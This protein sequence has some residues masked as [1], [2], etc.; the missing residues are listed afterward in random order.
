DLST[1]RA[2]IRDA[3][4]SAR[5]ADVALSGLLGAD[6]DSI[7][8]RGRILGASDA[9]LPQ[10]IEIGSGRFAA[11]SRGE[12]R[13]SISMDLPLGF[14]APPHPLLTGDIDATLDALLTPD[15]A[16]EIDALTLAGQQVSASARGRVSADNLDTTLS[17]QLDS[18]EQQGL[19]LAP[20]E[21]QLRAIGPLDSI[22]LEGEAA[23]AAAQY[24][25]FTIAAPSVQFDGSYSD[26]G[27]EGM[28]MSAAS[29]ENR[30]FRGRAT[31]GLVGATW[32]V[33]DLDAAFD[34]MSLRGAARG[35]G[36][37]DI[38]ADLVLNAP[39]GTLDGVGAISGNVQVSGAT[40]DTNFVVDGVSREGFRIDALAL[41]A[42]GPMAAIEGALELDG[43]ADLAE[44]EQAIELSLPFALD[45][46]ALT[47]QFSPNAIFGDTPITTEDPI[48]VALTETGVVASGALGLLGGR[49]DAE[50]I[51]GDR[52]ITLTGRARSIDAAALAR[53]V[54][55]PALRGALGAEFSLQGKADQL[56]GDL[57]LDLIN[58]A[59]ARP[60]APEIDGR[61]SLA[62]A[63]DVLQASLDLADT[64]GAVSLTG[65]AELPVLA[66]AAPFSIAPR[67]NARL[68]SRFDGQGAI[69]PIWSL[70][71][72]IDTAL[73][74]QFN[75]AATVR[76]PL[77]DLSPEGRLQIRQ[78]RLED[79]LVGLHLIDIDMD[80]D[81]SPEAVTVRSLTASGARGGSVTGSGRYGFGGTSSVELDLT[82]LNALQRSD[83]RA[84]VSGPLSLTDAATGARLTGALTFQS[85]EVNIDQLPTGGYTTLDVKFPNSN[86]EVDAQETPERVPIALDIDLKADR[87]IRVLGAGL[88]TEW[89]MDANLGGTARAPFLTGTAELVRGDVDVLGR[90]FPLAGSAIRFNGAIPDAELALQ[91]RRTDDGFTA[92]FEVTGTVRDPEF[93]LTSTPQVPDDEVLSRALF[94]TS[95]S[96]LSTLQAAQLAAGLAQLAGG[97]GP[98]LL[99]GLEDALDVDRIDLG[100]AEDGTASLGAGKYIADDV[101]L[102]ITTNTRG[103]PGLGVEWTPRDNVEV[104]AEFGTEVTPRFSI[105]WTRDYG[106]PDTPAETEPS[107]DESRDAAP[108]P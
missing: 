68:Q 3:V 4:L 56:S 31:I 107:T 87:R 36:A 9:P 81:L 5:A 30:T 83:L 89:R 47:A 6:R 17:I 96:Q 14:E 1:R 48:K 52:A 104:G 78:G 8:V 91:A 64:D 72:S 7:D 40:L 35:S 102:E 94:G 2:N 22:A 24:G 103:A 108:E 90:S 65:T 100:F 62:L 69:E 67:E 80:A 15:N 79:A 20:V 97:G 60:D 74:G 26:A 92:G 66:S 59:Q 61:L 25:E 34:A 37:E 84:V 39:T 105:Q 73:E 23:T 50:G 75:L 71:G 98:D 29:L 93:G 53:L 58:I 95:P 44:T 54:N 21:V 82:R 77:D 12:G 28:L 10:G 11:Q 38:S 43:V 51:R 101:Y 86:G 27:L 42:A 16:V 45:A 19:T 33:E 18:F 88:E 70:L 99:G 32:R 13:L 63:N 57:Q 85:A 49:I 55:R 106:G 41:R 76:G 46:E